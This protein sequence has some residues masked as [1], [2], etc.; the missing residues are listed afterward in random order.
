[1]QDDPVSNAGE[2]EFKFV[3]VPDSDDARLFIELSNY[4]ADLAEARHALDL[5]IT[6]RGDGSQLEHAGAYLIA[7]A[8]IAYCRTYFPSNVRK[9]LTEHIDIPGDLTDIHRIVGEFR[10]TT[11]AHSQ[12]KLATTFAM[13]VLERTTLE[14]R[15]VM[16]TTM[17]QTLPPPLVK[18][19]RDLVQTADDLL[20]EV[21]EQVRRR[22]VEQLTGSDKARIVAEGPLVTTVDA[23]DADFAPRTRRRPYPSSYTRYWSEASPHVN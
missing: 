20:S 13:G 7:F 23:L 12:S 15:D 1:M 19:F 4:G 6:S 8:I 16:A 5:A 22:L 11:I 10:N 18:R 9:R 14:V 21:T 3:M 17:S 2:E